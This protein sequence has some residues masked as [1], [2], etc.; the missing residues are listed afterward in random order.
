MV[1]FENA[2]QKMNEST[3]SNPVFYEKRTY[4][5][6]EIQDILGIGRD[7]AYKLCRSGLFRVVKVGKTVR[8]SKKSFDAWLEG[9]A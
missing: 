4:R 7:A 5:V 1:D 9:Y 8:I 3:L 6:D 2:I